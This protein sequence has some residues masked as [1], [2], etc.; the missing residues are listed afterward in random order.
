MKPEN[1]N[2]KCKCG[3]KLVPEE[4]RLVCSVCGQPTFSKALRHQY[5]ERNK[6]A[7]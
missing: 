5:L 3:G 7:S 2:G 4:D 1:N 6:A